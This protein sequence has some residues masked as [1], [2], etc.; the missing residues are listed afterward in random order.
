MKNYLILLAAAA[1]ETNTTNA[2]K[3]WKLR[4]ARR[5]NMTHWRDLK[6]ALLYRGMHYGSLQVREARRQVRQGEREPPDRHR[7]PFDEDQEAAG[8]SRG[9]H[10]YYYSVYAFSRTSCKLGCKTSKPPTQ[11]SSRPS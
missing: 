6:V 5:K 11:R 8:A 10:I 4:N 1:A 7:E 2:T 3:P 9:D